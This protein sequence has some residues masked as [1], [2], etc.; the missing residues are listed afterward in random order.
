[1]SSRPNVIWVTLESTRADHTTMGGH[2]RDTTPN[3]AALANDDAGRSFDDCF[4]HGIWTLSSSASILT[5]TYPS[6]HGAGMGAEAIPGSVPT[7]PERLR[8]AGYATACFSPN[9][10]LSSA[11][12]LDRGFDR[13]EWVSSS[14]LTDAVDTRTLL[15]YACNLRRHGGGLTLDPQKHTPDYLLNDRAKRWVRNTAGGDEPLFLYVHFGGPHRPYHPPR[16]LASRF[17]E[18]IDTDVDAAYDRSLD[19]H[20]RL[21]EYVAKGCTLSDDEY[22]ALSAL[23]DGEIAHA[24]EFVGDLV[25]TVQDA[26]EDTIV[27]V[28]ADHGELFGEQGL[29]AHQIAVDDAVSH[30]PLVVHGSDA[31]ANV[32]AGP[33]Q[34]A[35]VMRTLLELADAPVDGLQGHDLRQEKRDFAVIQRGGERARRNLDRIADLDDRFDPSRYHRAPLSAIRTGEFKL[36]YSEDAVDLYRLPDEETDVA[37][38]YPNVA[39]RLE[40]EIEDWLERTGRAASDEVEASFSEDMES[41]LADLG[42]IVE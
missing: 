28:T 24:D 12:D 42:Y 2:D 39:E 21:F 38:A 22:A 37:A 29:L 13:F 27:V 6:Y 17:C 14:S 18:E 4:A 5:G 7:I 8:D 30:V 19:V 16:R 26:L 23:Y 11:T 15:K 40:S 34:H 9:S 1:M 25:E 3:L 35:D 20:D 33:V 32:D 41:Q 36:L 31:L 10:H